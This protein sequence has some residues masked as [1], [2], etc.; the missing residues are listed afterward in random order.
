MAALYADEDFDYPVVECLRNFGHD[1]LTAKEAG[2][3]NKNIPDIDVLAFAIG[4]SRALV[5]HNRRHFI[6]LHHQVRS[7][8][9]IIVCTRDDDS[10]AL[11]QRIHLAL[12]KN[13]DLTDKLVRVN[14]PS[15]P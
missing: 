9:G 1:V 4:Q 3:A 5:T 2:Q 12:S 14:L 11:A 15:K 6:K 13:P 10:D 8:S 7:H